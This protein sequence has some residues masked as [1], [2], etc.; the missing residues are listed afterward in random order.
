MKEVDPAHGKVAIKKL[1]QYPDEPDHHWEIRKETLLDEAKRMVQAE[2]PNIV[3]VHQILR[4]ASDDT[5]H[6]V[7]EFCSGGS[8]QASFERG[9]L[10]L[11]QIQ[12]IASETLLGLDA[13]HARHMLH[14]DIKPGN[15][16]L[17][18]YGNVKIGDFG[19]VTDD[20]ILGYGS[21]AG[22]SNHL[23]P[24]V[25][26]DH[27]TSVQSDVWA[28]AMTLY[29]LT[30]GRQWCLQVG[31]TAEEVNKG[32]F[33]Q[34]LP[35]LPHVTDSWRRILR[36]AMHDDRQ[37]RYQNATQF[38]NAISSADCGPDWQ[39][40]VGAGHVKWERQTDARRFSVNWLTHSAQ[41]HE[42]SAT[43]YPLG[44][45]NR[46]DLGHAVGSKN[47]CVRALNKHFNGSRR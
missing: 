5:L 39:C 20:V 16:L 10:P 28:A 1:H 13:L 9:P 42:W 40:N 8:L 3:R 24:E 35:W 25:W 36:R 34:R 21:F 46:R 45:G 31:N 43:S 19:L 7:M 27:Q 41:K 23:A 4:H 6:L 32:N 12:K 18:Q 47:D 44:K 15:L 30:H 22:Y 11:S 17:D 14:R 37:Q 2:H 38:L 33:A 26:S 29:R